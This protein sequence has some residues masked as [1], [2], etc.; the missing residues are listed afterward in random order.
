M[1]SFEGYEGEIEGAFEVGRVGVGVEAHASLLAEVVEKEARAAHPLDVLLVGVE[2]AHAAH[3]ARHLCGC[4][5]ADGS[6][7][8][9]QYAGFDHDSSPDPAS[10]G[11]RSVNS[12]FKAA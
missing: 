7:S 10:T 1:R 9:Y 8:D 12:S 6:G 5:A 3:L 4:C 11:G 2:D